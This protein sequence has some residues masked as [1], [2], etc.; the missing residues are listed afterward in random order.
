[1]PANDFT[2]QKAHKCQGEEKQ[3]C[4]SLKNK[5]HN[6]F[7]RNNINKI[8]TNLIKAP[9]YRLD[10]PYNCFSIDKKLVFQYEPLNP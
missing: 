10:Y 8:D 5:K 6:C 3:L 7:V 4:F 9:I 1:M 2:L